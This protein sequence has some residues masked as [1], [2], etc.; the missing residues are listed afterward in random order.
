MPPVLPGL[1][2]F[3]PLNDKYEQ[4]S[5]LAITLELFFFAISIVS[6]K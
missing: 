4:R 1:K 3:N 5:A 6:P 2:L